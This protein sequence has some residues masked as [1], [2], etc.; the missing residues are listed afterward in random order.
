MSMP[1]VPPAA[2]PSPLADHL[3]SEVRNEERRED[4]DMDDGDEELLFDAAPTLQRA[5]KFLGNEVTSR[6][7]SVDSAAGKHQA[8]HR[9]L[10]AI[11]ISAG[12]GA[13]VFAI[14]QLTLKLTHPDWTEI[15]ANLEMAA[16]S[17]AVIAV[18]GG[19]WA[20]YDRKWIC[21][22]HQAERL[23]ILKFRALSKA[24][25][26]CGEFEAW[27]SWVSEQTSIID[28]A[29]EFDDVK[30]WC[31]TGLARPEPNPESNCGRGS[32]EIH[33]LKCYYRIKRLEFQSSFF[34]RQSEQFK[35]SIGRLHHLG[36]PIFF[37]SVVMVLIHFGA[38]G[39][40]SRLEHA[41]RANAAHFWEN[42]AIICVA[43]SALLPVLGLGIR[44]WLSAFELPRSAS[45]YRAKHYALAQASAQLE[46]A[47]LELPATL[48]YL[49]NNEFFL[50]N[51]HREWLRLISEAEWFI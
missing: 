51:E 10:A 22:R 35:R 40:A 5:L 19:I 1:E 25:L 18:C 13:I 46:T 2:S 3:S 16:V 21:A 33:A 14:L 30:G 12:V 50:E 47:E 36:L 4:F 32:S 24:E 42:L 37:L 15:A 7:R 45:L 23:R 44:A 48:K 38:E 34:Q 43:A 29:S 41:G 17:A 9:R 28:Q 11:A 27:Q 39:M 49:A 26:W 8:R 31:E 6:W 20:R